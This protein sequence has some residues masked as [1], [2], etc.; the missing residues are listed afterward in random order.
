MATKLIVA[1]ETHFCFNYVRIISNNYLY[2][3]AMKSQYLI[4]NASPNRKRNINH[5]WMDVMRADMTT[6]N[7]SILVDSSPNY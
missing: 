3:I 5:L 2:L 4:V 1:A 7:N 6:Q